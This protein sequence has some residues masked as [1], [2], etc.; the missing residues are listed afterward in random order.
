[1][2]E[3]GKKGQCVKRGGVFVNVI[4][5]SHTNKQ[6]D[7]K[8]TGALYKS[9]GCEAA[10]TAEASHTLFNVF[11]LLRA[12]KRLTVTG[13]APAAAG[14]LGRSSFRRWQKL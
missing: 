10:S 12:R 9:D 1:M 3:N 4:N 8:N 7:C 5:V 14:R 13:P 2:G 11:S 6:N